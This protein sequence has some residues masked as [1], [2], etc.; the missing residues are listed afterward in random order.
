MNT[1]L[2][3]K[4]MS[5]RAEDRYED[6]ALQVRVNFSETLL[7]DNPPLFT[8]NVAGLF[9]LF[10]S[11][12]SEEGCQHYTCRAC[13]KFVEKYGGL[14]I[15]TP[16]GKALPALWDSETVPPFFRA[17][18]KAMEKAI[19]RAKVNG[20]FI[21][22]DKT[23]GTPTTGEWHHLHVLHS[24][25]YQSTTR[26]AFQVMAERREEFKMII[27]GLLEYPPQAVDQALTLLKTDSLYRSE[28]VL[29]VAEWLSALHQKR[30]ETKNGAAK[31]NMTWLAVATAPTGFCH[32][33]STM[34]A[35]LL[36][37]IV[38]GLS[39]ETA[40]K[41]FSEKMHPLQ[42]QRPQ[43]APSE[44][45]IAQAEKV[46]EQ[47]KASGSLARRY[48]RLE[49]LTTIW[50]PVPPKAEPPS[51]P[52]VFAH[53]KAKGQTEVPA[54]ELPPITMTWDKFYKTVLPTAETIEYYVEG[55]LANYGAILTAVDPDAPPILQWDL[56]EAR[57]P[58]SWYLYHGGTAPHQWGLSVGYCPVSAVTFQPSM[59]QG[60]FDHQGR[61][62][63]FILD[64][65]KDSAHSGGLGLFPEILKSEFHGIRAT[66]EAYSRRGTTE[67]CEESSAC[68]LWFGSKNSGVKV[69]LRVKSAGQSLVYKLD[70][71]D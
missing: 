8:T 64:G 62:V 16:E 66:L 26:T 44:G 5:D 1:V 24:R 15:I 59:W 54:M 25:P 30:N 58:F 38:A 68:G 13:Q 42:Y 36:D 65:A 55:R 22:S 29:G 70:R 19:S 46:I 56:A 18:V 33:K 57:N 27:A 17:S 67:G 9:D 49:E 50:K 47:L 2:T 61:A 23:W 60:T 69:T 51:G 4:S 20:V 6:F 10:L 63:F 7:L 35:T 32:I 14:V 34:I 48:A 12:L 45:N 28:K 41:R 21:S 37:D 40:S 39:F 3:S 71:W 11:N 53:L 31:E 43:A 52:G